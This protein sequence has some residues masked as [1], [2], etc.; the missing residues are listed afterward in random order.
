[1]I[2]LRHQI[3][4]I[5]VITV[6]ILM[7][8]NH[9]LSKIKCHIQ[10]N[11]SEIENIKPI[12]DKQVELLLNSISQQL[13]S[14][15]NTVQKQIESLQKQ[16]LQ[17]I[18]INEKKS[19]NIQYVLNTTSNRIVDSNQKKINEI[20]SLIQEQ[21]Q[22]SLEKRLGESFKLVSNQLE[23]VH[24]GLGEMQHLVTGVGDL[25][26]LLSNVKIRGLWGET[27]LSNILN[28]VLTKSQYIENAQVD[29][30]STQRVEFAVKIPVPTADSKFIMLPIDAK[31]PL[32]EYHKLV[33]LYES[34]DKST[35]DKQLK[36]L[37]SCIKKEAKNIS[38]KYIKPPNT[39]DFAIMFLAI[40]GIYSEIIR[41]PDFLESI[42]RNFKVIIAG[43][44]TLTAL[45]SSIHIGLKAFTIEK[46]SNQVWSL[47]DSMKFEFKAFIGLLNKT[48]IKLDQAS[49]AIDAAE[50]KS[51]KITNK[52]DNINMSD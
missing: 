15:Q 20:K 34:S 13:L 47:L 7:I 49:K 28:Q 40:E 5:L 29:D 1:M 10:N 39:T 9:K 27:Q 38:D 44:T 52:L 18:E 14:N 45:L 16:L 17:I 41:A 25:K 3:L 32:T 8:I 24:R 42:Q 37:Q 19:D 50:Y 26:K 4:I 30:L 35:I 21:F 22:D 43:P 2:D 51:N 46:K 6:L 12:F 23:L 31:F 48:K 11:K 33:A 36:I